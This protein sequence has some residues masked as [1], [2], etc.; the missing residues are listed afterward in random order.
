MWRFCFTRIR[1]NPLSGKIWYHGSVR[2]WS[3]DSH[4]SLKT[5]WSVVIKSPNFRLVVKLRQCVFC[6]RFSLFWFSSRRRNFGLSEASEDTVFPRLR[7]HF[8]RMFR[9]R[10]LSNVCQCRHFCGNQILW[11]PLTTKSI[12]A[13]GSFLSFLT[14][15]QDSC[16]SFLVASFVT[17]P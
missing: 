11:N 1:L 16:P 14:F 17:S 7:C 2:W 10:I 5:L 13:N 6:K 15:S 4:P 8:R 9:F 12:S 3:P